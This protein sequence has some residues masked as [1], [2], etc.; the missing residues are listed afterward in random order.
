MAVIDLHENKKKSVL[1]GIS[2]GVD[3]AVGAYILKNQG[4]DVHAVTYILS[5]SQ[6][7]S[8]N[9][10]IKIAEKLN[11]PIYIDDKTDSFDKEVISYFT[12][13]YLIGETPNPCV[14]CN[15]SFKFRH[16]IERA[17]SMGIDYVATGHYANIDYDD[18][19]KRFLLTKS[20][21][22]KK[23]QSYFLYRL[24]QSQLSKIIFPISDMNKDQVRLIAQ[25]IGLEVK[26]K[27]DSQDI[28]FIKD[29][30]YASFIKEKTDRLFENST[31]IDKSGNTIG[32]GDNHIFYTPGQR[33]GL[34]QGFNK[35]VYVIKKDAMNNKV[36]LGDEADLY[37]K[38][39]KVKDINL[40][41]IEKLEEPMKVKVKIR[42]SMNFADGEISMV[43]DNIKIVFD[44]PVRAAVN[45]Q[46]AVFYKD[47]LVVG[48]GI[49]YD[50]L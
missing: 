34:G 9:D 39:I 27:K 24:T 48:G 43:D 20:A 37:K 47:N 10:A 50:A 32:K 36:V 1:I 12:N 7:S 19:S 33:R 35:R 23:D 49:I 14:L 13:A 8:V 21:N 18:K 28:C 44:E 46:S 25:K 11:I 26:D 29:T 30:D 2:G 45:G 40:I 4:Y 22:E 6:K 31:F 16:L 17:E 38:E 41:S 15:K 3:S 42:N 5:S